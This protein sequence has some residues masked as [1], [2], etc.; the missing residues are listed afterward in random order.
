MVVND[1]CIPAPAFFHGFADAWVLSKTAVPTYMFGALRKSCWYFFL[2]G[3]FFKSPLP[4]SIL[5]G[6]GLFFM[7]RRYRELSWSSWAPVAAAGAIFLVTLPVKYHAGMRHV[8]VLFPLFAMLGGAGAI[9]LWTAASAR[10]F[11]QAAL[12]VLLAWQ[13]YETILAQPDFIAYFNEFAG[14]DPSRV[15]VTGC[16]LDCGQDIFRL[17]QDLKT[18]NINSFNLAVW[19]SADMERI[20]LPH[21]GVLQ[22]F[23]PVDGW[24][25][26]SARSIRLGDVLHKTYPLE[27]LSWLE[28]YRPVARVGHTISLYYIPP[29][30]KSPPSSTTGGTDLKRQ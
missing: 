13:G 1:W 8:L 29:E 2:A 17:A 30:S 4:L 27:S 25:A 10:R 16:D 26:V 9:Y 11:A 28:K 23:R 18:R 5:C 7:A 12:I 15:L 20:G 22:P 19:S 14:T 21:F 3:V 6:I 24:V